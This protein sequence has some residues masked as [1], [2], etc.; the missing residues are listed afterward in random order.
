MFQNKMQLSGLQS[1]DIACSLAQALNTLHAKR[2]AHRD[3]KSANG[4]VT[5]FIAGYIAHVNSYYRLTNISNQSSE[6]LGHQ[7]C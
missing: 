1:I 7:N 2:I 4:M 3:I 6:T 5:L